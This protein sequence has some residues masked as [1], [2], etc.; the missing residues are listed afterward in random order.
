MSAYWS[1]FHTDEDRSEMHDLAEQHPD[2]V[3]ELA[4]LWM[5]EAKR[6]GVHVGGA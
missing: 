6:D 4:D 2:K 3:K 1:L 5:E